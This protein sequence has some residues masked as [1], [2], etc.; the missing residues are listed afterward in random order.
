MNLIEIRDIGL[1]ELAPF[2][3]LT[4]HA[5]R[6][7]YEPEKG[8]FIA[9]SATVTGVALDAGYRPLSCLIQRTRIEKEKELLARIGSLPGGD[10]IPIYTAEDALLEKLCG[11]PLSR[12]FFAAFPRPTLPD[13]RDLLA[14]SKRVAVLEGVVDP[15]NV[16]AILRSAAGI[17]IDAVLLSPTCSDPLRRRALR[18]SMGTSLLLPWT[19][20]ASTPAEWETAAPALLR[21]YGFTTVALALRNDALPLSDP[22]LRESEKLAILL[23]AEG[24]GLSEKVIAGSD[25]TV[26]IPMAR[27]VDS[28]NVAA[29]SAL[30]FWELRAR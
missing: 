6:A 3:K 16:G 25:Y 21:E 26:K 23:G 7:K 17:G 1:P 15:T 8:V 24:D 11:F 5:L 9:E 19:Y 28:L 30:A 10:S 4:D 27:G 2:A 20:L 14:K 22:R 18:V 13:P 29:A 12:G